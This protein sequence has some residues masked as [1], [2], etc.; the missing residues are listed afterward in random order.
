MARA[1]QRRRGRR[2]GLAWHQR[3]WR[4][5]APA[6]EANPGV[7]PVTA[8]ITHF[9]AGAAPL[10]KG[11]FDAALEHLAGDEFA[12]PA[13]IEFADRIGSE[14]AAVPHRRYPFGNIHHLVEPVTDKKVGYV[15]TL[16]LM[17]DSSEP[18]TSW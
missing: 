18:S 11:Q 5:P 2:P 3:A 1:G 4:E 10:E 9:S 6:V 16:E 7:W 12:Q 13:P 14:I 8:Q 15:L 17:D